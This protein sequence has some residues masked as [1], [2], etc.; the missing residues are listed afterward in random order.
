MQFS[1]GLLLIGLTIV[2]GTACGSANYLGSVTNE[3]GVFRDRTG[4]MTETDLYDRLPMILARYGYF[5]LE[6]DRHDKTLIFETQWKDRP[7]FEDETVRGAVSART[8]FRLRAVQSGSMY[9][10]WLEAD[11]MIETSRNA[12]IIMPIYDELREYMTGIATEL[13]LELASGIRRH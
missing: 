2:Q 12:W 4:H 8:R 5:I 7:P 11:N 1:A 13:R 6:H 10:T 9:S 3:Y